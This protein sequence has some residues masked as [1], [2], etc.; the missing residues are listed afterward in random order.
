M[1][2][3]A[4]GSIDLSGT[5]RA[6]PAGDERRVAARGDDFDDAGWDSL[7]VPSHWWSHPAFDA[8]DGPVLHRTRFATPPAFGPGHDGGGEAEAERRTHL[9]F[10][11]IFYSSDCWLDGEYLG[12][13]EG[14]F[15]P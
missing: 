2:A 6:A 15:F 4:S 12:D 14:Y 13:T 3:G 8:F 5:W 9:V 1:D 7:A 11:G 10:D